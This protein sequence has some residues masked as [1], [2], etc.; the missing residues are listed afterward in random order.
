MKNIIS[1]KFNPAKLKLNQFIEFYEY[2]SQWDQNI[3]VYGNREAHRIHRL[4]ELLSFILFNHDGECLLVIE[5]SGITETKAYISKNFAE[6]MT[7]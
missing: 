3:Y 4:S 2:C 1:F 6:V 5:G 7:A